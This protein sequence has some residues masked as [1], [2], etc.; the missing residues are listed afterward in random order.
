MVDAWDRSLVE[1]SFPADAD[2]SGTGVVYYV[3]EPDNYD[4]SKPMDAAEYAAWE[5]SWLQGAAEV[6]PDYQPI[7]AESIL[8]CRPPVE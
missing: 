5:A 2:R 6:K 8:E 3:M 1:D 4:L 7:T